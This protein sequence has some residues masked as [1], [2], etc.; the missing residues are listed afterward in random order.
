M[1]YAC[2]MSLN[3]LS[4]LYSQLDG[5]NHSTQSQ[6]LAPEFLY[7]VVEE[8][9]GGSFFSVLAG[10]DLDFEHDTVRGQISFCN[11]FL[12]RSFLRTVSHYYLL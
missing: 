6:G 10:H 9:E 3:F 1:Y 5:S 2:F 4:L 11:N 8:N 7:Y 12:L